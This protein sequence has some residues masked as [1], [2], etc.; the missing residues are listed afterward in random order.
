MQASPTEQQHPA[1]TGWNSRRYLLPSLRSIRFLARQAQSLAQPVHAV[2]KLSAGCS[3]A[4]VYHPGSKAQMH[5]P[6]VLITCPAGPASHV[7]VWLTLALQGG[8]LH[9]GLTQDMSFSECTSTH[10]GEVL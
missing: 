8:R 7:S 10:D 3:L 2:C 4:E 5:L 6:W 9:W 1:L